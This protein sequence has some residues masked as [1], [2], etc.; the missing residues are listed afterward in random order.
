MKKNFVESKCYPEDISKDIR[1][2][3]DVRKSC[4]NFKMVEEHLRYREKKRGDM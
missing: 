3:A 2:K 1:K 4:R